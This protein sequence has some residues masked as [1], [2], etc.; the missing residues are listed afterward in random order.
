MTNNIFCEPSPGL[1]AHTAASRLLVEDNVLQD[2]VG[3]NSEDIFPA[4]ANVLTSLKTHPEATSLTRTGFNFA[5]DTVDKEP[6]FVTFGKDPARAKR[7]GGAMASLTGGE[8][9][10][11]S[12]LVDNWDLSDLDANGGTLV[13]IGGSHGFV[14]VELAKRWTNMKFIVQDLPKTVESA[15]SPICDDEPVAQRIELQAHDFFKEQPAKNADGTFLIDCH[16]RCRTF[17]ANQT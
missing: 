8:G 5:F 15:P 7:M 9:Y 2:W 16:P 1:V 14:S 6:M 17:L 3:F 12:Y 4:A 11:L 13:D 10:Q